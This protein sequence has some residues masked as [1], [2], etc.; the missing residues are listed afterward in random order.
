[1]PETSSWIYAND[2]RQRRKNFVLKKLHSGLTPG[3][4]ADFLAAMKTQRDTRG[5]AVTGRREQARGGKRD[6]GRSLAKW[7]SRGVLLGGA[8]LW[9]SSCATAPGPMPSAPADATAAGRDASAAPAAESRPGLATGYGEELRNP[10]RQQNFARKSSKPAGTDRIYYNDR[11]GVA[12]MAP[13]RSRTKGLAN[14]AGGLVEWG[15]KSGP[16]YAPTYRS[17][18]RRFV[19]GSPGDDYTIVVKNRCQSRVEVVLSVDGLDVMDGEPAAF[20]KRGYLIDSGDT[21]EVKGWRSGWDTVA[22][23]EF[24]SVADSYANLRHGD[25][26]HVGVI[27]LA[28]FDEKGVDPWHW[29]PNE[30]EM[31]GSARPFAT[32]P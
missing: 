10:T 5:R 22:R 8:A 21:L 23:F 16:G 24:S 9:W 26:R 14:A 19:A 20:S 17:G 15:I 7:L 31:R 1:M 27:G 12:A 13:R 3:R 2:G 18:G 25:A 30:V 4:N 11:K 29:K 28:V 32:A 6:R